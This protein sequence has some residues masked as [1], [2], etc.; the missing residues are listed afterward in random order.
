MWTRAHI[1][2]Y[3]YAHIG[4]TTMRN[5]KTKNKLDKQEEMQQK[6]IKFRE[7]VENKTEL[8]ERPRIITKCPW[9]NRVK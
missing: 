6:L 9:E 3:I 7:E 5:L 2:T 1:Q 4:T 8:P